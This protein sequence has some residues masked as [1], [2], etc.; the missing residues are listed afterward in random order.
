M[1]VDPTGPTWEVVAVAGGTII[2]ILLSI[3]ISLIAAYAKGL[4]KR[5]DI[6]EV[7]HHNLNDRVLSQY[8][9]KTETN[10]LLGEVKESIVSL[11]GRF[12][13]LLNQ[14]AKDNK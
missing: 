2:T 5:I 11:H 4:G 8:H 6:L 14:Q 13:M 7:A 1:A 12:D 3:I 9:D 10:R